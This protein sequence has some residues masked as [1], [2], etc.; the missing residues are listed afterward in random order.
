MFCID[1]INDQNEPAFKRISRSNIK[2]TGYLNKYRESIVST[3]SKRGRAD[4]LDL[5]SENKNLNKELAMYKSMVM[6]LSKQWSSRN[7]I[8]SEIHSIIIDYKE[9]QKKL[10]ADEFERVTH[11][12]KIYKY[13]YEDELLA[14]RKMIEEL[15]KII[16]DLY[17]K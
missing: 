10:L 11:I 13:F 4:G 3:G 14:K 1:D 12:M 7:S 5:V 9:D 16:D 2:K 6:S 8:D 15:A 17:V